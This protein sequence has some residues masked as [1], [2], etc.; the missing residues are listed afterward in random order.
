MTESIQKMPA[1]LGSLKT[2]K[3]NLYDIIPGAAT[4]TIAPPMVRVKTLR[5]KTK[6]IWENMFVPLRAVERGF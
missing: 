6:T 1:S 5:C 4:C 2:N 3:Y